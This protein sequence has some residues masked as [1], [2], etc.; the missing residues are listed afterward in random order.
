MTVKWTL[1]TA[2]NWCLSEPMP[3]IATVGMIKIVTPFWKPFSYVRQLY[4][5]RNELSKK[6]VKRYRLV[7]VWLIVCLWTEVVAIR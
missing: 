1:S 7:S 6:L 5:F 4:E 2:A 3:A